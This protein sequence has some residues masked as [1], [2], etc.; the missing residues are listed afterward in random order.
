MGRA[1]NFQ[2]PTLQF[3]F[4]EP[5]LSTTV[6]VGEGTSS[7]TASTRKPLGWDSSLWSQ[8]RGRL[9]PGTLIWPDL[10]ETDHSLLLE[11][12]APCPLGSL[13]LLKSPWFCV[14]PQCPILPLGPPPWGALLASALNHLPYASSWRPLGISCSAGLCLSPPSPKHQVAQALTTGHSPAPPALPTPSS[15]NLNS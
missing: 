12:V 9:G 2:I 11:N 13:F 6:A 15:T 1:W 5:S 10:V 8:S 3:S 7:L 4:G 14:G